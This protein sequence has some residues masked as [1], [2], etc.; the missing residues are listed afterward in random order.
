M[1]LQ[2]DILWLDVS[3]SNL[4]S[5]QVGNGR[6]DAGV[7]LVEQS[8]TI[9]TSNAKPVA[10]VKQIALVGVLQNEGDV[11]DIDNMTQKRKNI[12][13]IQTG[14]DMR[15][16][17]ERKGMTLARCL[18]RSRNKVTS[19]EWKSPALAIPTFDF[20]A[21]QRKSAVGFCSASRRRAYAYV[22]DALVQQIQIDLV[23]EWPR[24]S[25]PK[26]GSGDYWEVCDIVLSLFVWA[27]MLS[28]GHGLPGEK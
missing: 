11:L 24:V 12:W 25:N 18:L 21:R 9:Q 8:G 5:F 2:Q 4:K 7:D 23:P 15:A 28:R 1:A 26:D 13:V 27:K 14:K 3:M 10:V 16:R 22:R 17:G 6:D 19:D 20:L